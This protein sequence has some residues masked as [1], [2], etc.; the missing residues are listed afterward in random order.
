MIARMALAAGLLSATL[1][2]WSA[3]IKVDFGFYGG[4]GP[5]NR[6]KLAFQFKLNAAA[7]IWTGITVIL[8]AIGSQAFL[9]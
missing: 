4:L 1:W 5:E 3:L 6:R 8:C 2:F 9:K 7:A